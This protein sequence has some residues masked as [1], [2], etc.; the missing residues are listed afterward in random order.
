MGERK[1]GEIA[2]HTPDD[3]GSCSSNFGSTDEPQ[4]Q[5]RNCKAE[6]DVATAHPPAISHPIAPRG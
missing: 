5:R 4:E 6:L 2:T 3:A 1:G